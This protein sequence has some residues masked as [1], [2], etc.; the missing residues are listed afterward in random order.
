[1]KPGSTGRGFLEARN[2]FRQRH[3]F[4][5]IDCNFQTF[6]LDRFSGGSTGN[7]TPSFLNISRSYF[8]DEVGR[9]FLAEAMFFLAM[10]AILALTFVSGVRVIIQ[11]LQ[12]S[13]A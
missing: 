12:L 10:A 11:F 1:M 13:A 7:P 9:N 8:R 6:S 4:P 3:A 2:S 5:V